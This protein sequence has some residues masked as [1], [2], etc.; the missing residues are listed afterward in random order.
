[1]GERYKAIGVAT[2]LLILFAFAH[3]PAF[4]ADRYASPTGSGST[5][6]EASPCSVQEAINQAQ[7]G[8]SVILKDGTYTPSVNYDTVRDGTSTAKITITAQNVHKAVIEPEPNTTSNSRRNFSIRHAHVVLKNIL[9]DGKNEC[10]FEVLRIRGPV[11][12]LIEGVI[13]ENMIIRRNYR[14]GI[15]VQRSR[16]AILRWNRLEDGGTVGGFYVGLG[17]SIGEDQE[18]R[19]AEIYANTILRPGMECID[20]KKNTSD[21]VFHHNICDDAGWLGDATGKRNPNGGSDTNGAVV[22]GGGSGDNHRFH[23]NIIRRYKVPSW[24]GALTVFGPRIVKFDGNVIRDSVHGKATGSNE[25]AKNLARVDINGNTWCNLVNSDFVVG[26]GWTYSNN[27]GLP[28]PNAPASAC[29]AEESRILKERDVLPG[30]PSGCT[31][32]CDS[33]APSSPTGLTIIQ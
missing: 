1:M 24:G 9:I 32:G 7:P 13:V 19:N 18:V 31:I 14:V 12:N 8:E 3:V 2:A 30:N 25:E 6:S 28:A 26:P 16:G 23:D 27:N 22:V 17:G 21:S 10:C 15:R 29:D 33:Q 11:G 4:A 5:C 20:F